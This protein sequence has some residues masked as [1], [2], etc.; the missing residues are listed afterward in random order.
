MKNLLLWIRD[1]YF[2]TPEE[3]AAR[4]ERQRIKDLCTYDCRRCF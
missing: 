2:Y 4:K 3:K 1:F